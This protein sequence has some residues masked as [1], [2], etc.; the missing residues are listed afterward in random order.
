[1]TL[2][3]NSTLITTCILDLRKRPE[4]IGIDGLRIERKKI[5][6]EIVETPEG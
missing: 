6:K 1:M 2:I 3:N 4:C 5:I